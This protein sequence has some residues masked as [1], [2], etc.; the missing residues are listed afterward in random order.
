[1]HYQAVISAILKSTRK[2]C[3]R[4]HYFV[5]NNCFF[6]CG[7][8]FGILLIFV[9][10][11]E[12]YFYIYF[13]NILFSFIFLHQIILYLFHACTF[14]LFCYHYNIFWLCL[15]LFFCFF[16]NKQFCHHL[17][18]HLIR[19]SIY[20]LFFRYNEKII[21]THFFHS[22]QNSLLYLQHHLCPYTQNKF[23]IRILYYIYSIIF[24]HIPKINSRLEFFI[25]FIASS[26]LIYP[27]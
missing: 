4:Q 26:L 11:L 24:A 18:Y 16:D 12:T 23:Q 19:H 5:N 17:F 2:G 6:S 13:F 7:N 14:N 9:Y 27:K 25:I 15:I 3:L 20:H 21:T 1:M 22:D 10:F 8:F